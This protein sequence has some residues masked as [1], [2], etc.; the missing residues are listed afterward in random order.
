MLKDFPHI[1]KNG[2][3]ITTK[4]GYWTGGFWVGLLWFSYKMS[5]NE[6]YKKLAYN[7]LWKLERRKKDRTFDL[8]F[9]FFPSFVFGY[10]L[11]GDNRLKRTAIEAANVLSTLSHAKTGFI[12][13]KIE[14]N[15]GR[16]AI[17][18]MMNLQLLWWAYKETMDEK[19]LK[20]AYVHS[21]RTI[22]EFIREDYSTVHV[23]DFN[24]ETG[25]I[26]RRITVQGYSN[27]SCW[28]R[29]QSWAIYG[30]TS[31]YRYVK[32]NIFLKT[33][34]NLARYFI[35]NLPEDYVPYWDF[36]DPNGDIKDSSAGAIAASALLDLSEFKGE[37]NFKE[38]A[39]SIL[40]SLCNNYLVK[41]DKDGILGHGCFHKP[42]NIGVDESLIWGDYYFMESI[43][44]IM[45]GVE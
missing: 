32:N 27:N 35:R 19:F 21:R 30:F 6:K 9:L 17:D 24:L 26:I 5:G 34:E 22:E 3:W 2:K 7:W 29:G 12:Y 18:V 40:C 8:G 16:T 28:S 45:E 36:N 42:A 23:I 43:A 14:E 33:A 38:V 1:T 39:M 41:E 10:E 20:A 31:A 44:K 13:N 11:T 4:D 15:I 25:E 37:E